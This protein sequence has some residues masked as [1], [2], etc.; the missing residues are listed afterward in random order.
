M[1]WALAPLLAAAAVAAA[2]VPVAAVP[3]AA[4]NLSVP[5][6]LEQ[7]AARLP[8]G[9]YLHCPNGSHLAMYDDQQTYFTG[10]V[11]FLRRLPQ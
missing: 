10:L 5:A 4:A 7:M 8:N 11:D 6:H 9:A 3:A 2:V 1:R